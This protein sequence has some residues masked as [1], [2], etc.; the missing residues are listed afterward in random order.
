[1]MKDAYDTMFQEVRR[2]MIRNARALDLCR[3][4]FHFEGGSAED[5][6][7]ALSAYQNN[8]GGFG[9]ALEADCWNP[10]SSPL[11]TGEAIKLLN[12]I[13]FHD[14]AHPLIQGILR[15]L[16]SAEHMENGKWLFAIPSN[17][18]YPHAPWWSYSQDGNA[19]MGYNPTAIL[20]GFLLRFADRASDCFQTALSIAMEMQQKALAA[21][22][23]EAH[24]L[25]CYGSFVEDAERAGL[26]GIIAISEMKES[27]KKQVDAAIER[28]PRKWPMYTMRPSMYMRSRDSFF[29]PGNEDIAR[30]E[31][32]YL[33]ST[34][35]SGGVWDIMWNWADYPK[36]FA[37]SEN[38][39][40]GVCATNN[41]LF[42][43]EFG[44]IA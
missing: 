9:H 42:V 28:D 14:P 37:V 17:D 26:D 41:M 18:E 5:V 33:M 39:W 12:E 10:N 38:W 11:T 30:A 22:A 29:Y 34:R 25:M 6:A 35:H 36:A 21:E 15:Y 44:T 16:A 13:G 32:D 27:L 19:A 7:M 3:W 23:I 31:I 2:W 40:M 43:R 1:M 8:D 4:R 20:V 24:E